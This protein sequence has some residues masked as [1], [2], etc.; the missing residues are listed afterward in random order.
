MENESILSERAKKAGEKI[1]ESLQK[2][3]KYLRSVSGWIRQS[4]YYLWDDYKHRSRD[5]KVPM[6]PDG[7]ELMI[8]INNEVTG[9][10]YPIAR[11]SGLELVPFVKDRVHK[12]LE[13]IR[14]N[15]D[16]MDETD[17]LHEDI[18]KKTDKTLLYR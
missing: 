3:T 18:T 13:P 2:A 9:T 17:R 8:W 5:Y 16:W 4:E 10:L 12:F 14:N 1:K 15:K 11:A 7:M 6:S